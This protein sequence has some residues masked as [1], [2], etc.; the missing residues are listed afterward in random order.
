MEL[1]AGDSLLVAL[2]ALDSLKAFQVALRR[3]ALGGNA[4]NSLFARARV[5]AEADKTP[6]D[7]AVG[8]RRAIDEHTSVGVLLRSD[9]TMGVRYDTAAAVGGECRVRGFIA[10]NINFNDAQ[11]RARMQYGLSLE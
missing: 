10:A 1:K 4:H 9:R 8:F 7:A 3:D 11:D 5:C 6:I 2:S